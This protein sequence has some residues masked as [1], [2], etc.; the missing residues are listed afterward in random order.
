M[1][2]PSFLQVAPDRRL[3]Y[4]RLEGRAPAVLF[5]GG[6]TS[7][8]TF[9]VQAVE[10]PARAAAGYVAATTVFAVAACALGWL[11]GNALV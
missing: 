11:V 5:C 9:A 6:F 3:A 4:H 10:R 1:S 8:S 7:F 2:E